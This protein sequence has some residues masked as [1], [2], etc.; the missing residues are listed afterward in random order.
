MSGVFKFKQFEVDQ[1]GCAMK[2]NTDGVLLGALAD[3]DDP[4]A[5]LDIGTGTGVI[6]LMLAQRF[7]TAQVDAIEIDEQ[8]AETAG[9]NFSNSPFAE[10]LTAYSMGFEKFFAENPGKKYDLIVSN[11]PFYIN[12]LKSPQKNK[13][14]AKHAGDDFFEALIREVSEHINE[15]GVFCMILPLDTA[16]ALSDLYLKYNMR[17]QQLVN[18]RSFPLSQPHRVIVCLGLEKAEIKKD[19]FLIY[20]SK[21]S[22]SE[23]YVKLLK[24]YFTVF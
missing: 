12:S 8:A 2:I 18:V 23:E 24:P 11:P 16:E 20:E 10:R 21:D 13:Q 6:A 5:I 4:K 22:Y 19:S 1:T 17:P 9:R 15:T 7:G 3:A 14:V